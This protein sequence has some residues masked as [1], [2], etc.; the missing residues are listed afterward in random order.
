MPYAGA[1]QPAECARIWTHFTSPNSVTLKGLLLQPDGNLQYDD[2]LDSSNLY[3][4]LMFARLR[5]DDERMINTLKAVEERLLNTSPIGGVIRDEQDGYFLAKQQ[6]KGNP[7]VVC[8]LWLAQYYI[9]IGKLDKANELT[10]WS[11]ARA[12]PSGAI[13][14]Q[15]DPETG[16]ALSV[17]PLVWSH[18]EMVNTL[19]DLTQAAQVV[20]D[21]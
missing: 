9:A 21:K 4:P 18:A 13:S 14:E 16:F 15:F 6:Y 20:P 3:G 5:L 1:V 11:M 19:L 2:K 10:E 7:W 17:T 12:Y 8:S